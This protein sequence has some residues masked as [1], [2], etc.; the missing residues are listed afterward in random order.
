VASDRDRLTDALTVLAAV[1]GVIA[2][3]LA[4][5]LAWAVTGWATE[6]L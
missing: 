4:L 1:I 5:V 6:M 3:G 2:M